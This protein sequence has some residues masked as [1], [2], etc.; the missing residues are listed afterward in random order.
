MSFVAQVVRSHGGNAGHKFSKFS[1]F[2][3]GSKR[4]GDEYDASNSSYVPRKRIR[5]AR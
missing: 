4:Y 2:S 3:S 5:F 1:K